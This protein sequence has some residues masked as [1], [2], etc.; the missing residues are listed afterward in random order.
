MMTQKSRRRRDFF[1]GLALALT[2]SAA[3]ALVLG[4]VFEVASGPTAPPSGTLAPEFSATTVDGETVELSA[5]E[6]RVVLLDF[7]ATWCGPCVRSLPELER[8]HRR[9]REDG[10]VVLGINQEPNRV[11][12]VRSFLRT[13]DIPFPSVRDDRDIAWKYGDHLF[14]TTVLVGPDRTVL[15]T[16]R[17]PPDPARLEADVQRALAPSGGRSARN[18]TPSG[19]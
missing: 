16:Y 10:L 4:R 15:A 9:Y 8:L 6:G 5:Y 14:P 2:M 1:S 11:E 18:P 7:W 17:G 19:G 12:H 3:F 13:H